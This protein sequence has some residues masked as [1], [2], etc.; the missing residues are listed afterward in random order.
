MTAI[1]RSGDNRV[2]QGDGVI[3]ACISVRRVKRQEEIKVGMFIDRL[4]V[5]FAA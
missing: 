3:G 5:N 4:A 1:D 2:A